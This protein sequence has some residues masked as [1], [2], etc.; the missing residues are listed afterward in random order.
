MTT[1]ELIKE[2]MAKEIFGMGRQEAFDK[3]ICIDCKQPA[4]SRCPS[5]LSL[6]EYHISGLCGICQDRIFKEV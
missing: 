5:E 6:R 3:G 1:L 4:L 2:N